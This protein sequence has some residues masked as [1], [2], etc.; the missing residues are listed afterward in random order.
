MSGP[1]VDSSARVRARIRALKLVLDDL[2][3]P[4]REIRLAAEALQCKKE[5]DGILKWL[6]AEVKGEIDLEKIFYGG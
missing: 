5:L 2:E 3:N 4:N 1:F 6:L